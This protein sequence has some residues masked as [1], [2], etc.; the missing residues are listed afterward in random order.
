[1]KTLEDRVIF[2]CHNEDAVLSLDMTLIEF[3]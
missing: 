3:T 1:M 2:S